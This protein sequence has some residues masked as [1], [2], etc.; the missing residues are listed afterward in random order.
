MGDEE[1]VRLVQEVRDQR[2]EVEPLQCGHPES[3][4][5][6]QGQNEE[7]G[8]NEIDAKKSKK[9]SQL[10]TT[11]QPPKALTGMFFVALVV[12]VVRGQRASVKIDADP[13]SVDSRKKTRQQRPSRRR[14]RAIGVCRDLNFSNVL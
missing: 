14:Q 2:K 11:T 1:P 7:Q 10:N 12:V 13:P 9:K 5:P 3:V 6:G 8:E 4:Q